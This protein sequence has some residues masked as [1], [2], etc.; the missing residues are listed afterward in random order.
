MHDGGLRAGRVVHADRLAGA[1]P[2]SLPLGHERRVGHDGGCGGQVLAELLPV[3]KGVGKLNERVCANLVC[4]LAKDDVRGH[5]KGLLQA[6]GAV[7]LVGRVGDRCVTNVHGA[8]R[9]VGAGQAGGTGLECR[10]K[11]N[12]LKRGARGVQRVHGAIVHGAVLA[13]SRLQ[14]GIDVGVVVGG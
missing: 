13:A 6:D 5:G 2:G 7:A 11:R 12:D 14:Q 4:H 3:A 9:L 10:R 8:G 1:G